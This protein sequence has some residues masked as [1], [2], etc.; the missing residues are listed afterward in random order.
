MRP[1]SLGLKETECFSLSE[2][3]GSIEV[4][5]Q[6][7]AHVQAMPF[8][9]PRVVRVK[10]E[11]RKDNLLGPVEHGN[12]LRH[13]GRIGEENHLILLD[14]AKFPGHGEGRYLRNSPG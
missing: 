2:G 4:E 6:G 12:Y 10:A 7:L 5:G 9:L 1:C 3:G 14:L 8:M 11:G 13:K